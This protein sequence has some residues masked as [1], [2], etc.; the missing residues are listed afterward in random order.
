MKLEQTFAAAT[1]PVPRARPF[2]GGVDEEREM[3]I[4][5]LLET[6][7]AGW[8]AHLDRYAASWPRPALRLVPD[9]CR[10]ELAATEEASVEGLRSGE[11]VARRRA[12]RAAIQRRRRA[13]VLAA[14][15]AGAAC[16]LALPL[17][18]LGGSPVAAHAQG[19]AAIAGETVYVAR[20]GDTLWSI[21][22]QFD[23]GGSPRPM[24]EALAR[25]IGSAVVVPG[26]RIPIPW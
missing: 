20:P 13:V 16:A 26:E 4:A 10:A 6:E 3:A 19:A 12:R 2:D 25:E 15:A 18:S 22:A 8:S 21:A 9:R 23:H 5:P 1:D 11:D 17:A 14:V 7:A 24:A